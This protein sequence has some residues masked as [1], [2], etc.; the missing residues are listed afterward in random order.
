MGSWFSLSGDPET[1]QAEAIIRGESWCE[2]LANRPQ[3]ALAPGLLALGSVLLALLYVL[4]GFPYT[5]GLHP[6]NFSQRV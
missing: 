5:L 2:I 1:V 3:F 6:R 4:R